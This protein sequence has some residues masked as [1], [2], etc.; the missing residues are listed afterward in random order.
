MSTELDFLRTIP[1]FK[2]L[3]PAELDRVGPVTRSRLAR[4]GEILFDQGDPSDGA[5][6]LRSGEADVELVLPNLRTRL[7]T[8]LGPGRVVGELCLVENA[9]R[10]MRVRVWTM[11]ELVIVDRGR[12][13]ALR[14]AQ[15]PAAYKIIRNIL[16]VLC[17][18]L[19]ATNKQLDEGLRASG[20]E[21]AVVPVGPPQ[22]ATKSSAWAQLRGL[23]VGRAR[24]ATA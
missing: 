22:G 15:D 3:S 20:Q 21:P 18:R 10:S 9:P 14:A 6:V 23:L 17:G 8:H 13:E 2:G 11:A 7:L 12:F 4:P 24:D 1:L 5:Y 19:R 16:L